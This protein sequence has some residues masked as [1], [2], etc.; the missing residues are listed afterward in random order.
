VLV[1]QET[2]GQVVHGRAE[3]TAGNEG[4]DTVTVRLDKTKP[5]IS[6]TPSGTLG[7][8][9]WYKSA[10]T[11]AFDCADPGTVASGIATCP[12]KQTLGHDATAN[13]KAIDTAGNSSAESVGPVKVDGQAP[14]IS[15]TGVQD[16]GVYFLGD[17][18]HGRAGRTTSA[19][20]G[21]TAAANCRS[22]AGSPTASDV[23][24]H[25]DRQ[26][27]GGERLDPDRHLQGP[28]PDRLQHGVLAA[29]HQRHRAHGELDHQRVQGGQ[30]RAGEVPAHRR[31]WQVCSGEHAAGLDHAGQGQRHHGDSRRGVYTSPSDTTSTFKW[32]ATDEHYQFNWGSPKN[33]AGFHWRIGVKLD[34]GTM[35]AV[36]IALR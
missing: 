21:W 34:D 20:P 8:N 33:G 15:L 12:G 25:R 7:S 27:H 32:S 11:V 5:T 31:Q 9:G 16:G 30:H 14:V 1:D 24:L 29:A 13:G 17:V 4:T 2:A 28:L 23:Q 6:G 35:Q 26:G 36:N 18:R 10:V 22:A 19:R 3:D